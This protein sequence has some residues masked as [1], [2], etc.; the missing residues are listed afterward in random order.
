MSNLPRT[1]KLC[2]VLLFLCL[3]SARA[4]D[5]DGFYRPDALPQSAQLSQ[6]V[7]DRALQASFLLVMKDQPCSA[8]FI[9]SKGYFLTAAHCVLRV[10]S[11][12]DMLKIK[13][14]GGDQTGLRVDV[15][16][17]A[18]SDGTF[19]GM[20]AT[21]EGIADPLSEHDLVVGAFH[22]GWAKVILAGKAFISTF[23][24]INFDQGDNLGIPDEMWAEFRKHS[25]DFVIMKMD[26]DKPTPCVKL[27]TEPT[28]EGTKLWG[29]GFP[30]KVPPEYGVDVLGEGPYVSVGRVRPISK[31]RDFPGDDVISEKA[32]EAYS[33][34]IQDPERTFHASNPVHNRMS[35]AMVINESGIVEGISTAGHF[36]QFGSTVA[37]AS[38]IVS[39]IRS[40]LS[41]DLAND[42]LDCN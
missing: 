31:E 3:S 35:G 1:G 2:G 24:Q 9:S 23:P 38:H 4:A 37:R 36:M 18:P 13:Y 14:S 26:L 22:G 41:K 15:H 12:A 32:L 20:L 16:E 39:Q 27:A 29:V 11:V 40:L 34:L 5:D 21:R 42:V 17:Q 19:R 6:G 33:S 25:E 10:E 8:Q 28:S 7:L 30:K